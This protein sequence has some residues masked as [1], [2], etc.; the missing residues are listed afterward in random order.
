MAWATGED[1]MQRVEALIKA[2]HSQF[3]I[4]MELQGPPV[5]SSPFSRMTYREAMSRHGS[6]KPDLRIEGLV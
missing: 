2:V 6:D 4:S 3:Q 1:V 5:Q